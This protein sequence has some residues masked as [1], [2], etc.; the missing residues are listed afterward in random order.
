MKTPVLTNHLYKRHLFTESDNQTDSKPSNMGKTKE[1]S[2]DLRDRIVDL[3]KSGIGYKNISKM[4]GIKVTTIGAIVRK[5]KKFNMTITRP[6]SGAPQKISPRGVARIMRTVR[7]RPATTQRE[8]VN[9]LKAAGTTVT[10]KTIGNTLR[11]NGLTSCSARKVPLLKKAHVEA[12]L[13]YAE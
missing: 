7:N 8:L 9:D 4:L 12:R 1:L 13:K 5:F 11:H 3:H 6:R 2:Q 10:R